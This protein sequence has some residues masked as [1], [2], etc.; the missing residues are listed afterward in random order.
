[1]CIR[2]WDNIFESIMNMARKQK[3]SRISQQKMHNP[4]RQVKKRTHR[5]T[6]KIEIT[7][8]FFQGNNTVWMQTVVRNLRGRCVDSVS[9]S[10]KGNCASH[11]HHRSHTETV[12]GSKRWNQTWTA[13]TAAAMMCRHDEKLKQQFTKKEKRNMPTIN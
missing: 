12:P 7:L 8:K 13:T 11:N 2:E 9:S 5:R 1:M 3:S 4:V 6:E 10:Q